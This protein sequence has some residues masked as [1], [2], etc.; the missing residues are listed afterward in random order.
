MVGLHVLFLISC[1]IEAIFHDSSFLG[2]LRA[3]AFIGAVLWQAL[4][5][6]AVGTLGDG[7]NTRV[8]VVPK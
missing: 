8:I 1:A 2:A 5:Y 6:W 3:V 4:R 7:W